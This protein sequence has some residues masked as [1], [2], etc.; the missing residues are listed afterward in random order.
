MTLEDNQKPTLNNKPIVSKGWRFSAICSLAS[1]FLLLG[2][3]GGLFLSLSGYLLKIFSIDS[4]NAIGENAW[5]LA[6]VISLLWPVSF[7][8]ISMRIYKVSPQLSPTRRNIL[9][10][11]LSLLFGIAIALVLTIIVIST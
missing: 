6:L 2:L 7:V 9:T 8:P 3:P 11:L 1:C 4:F 5:P 10:F